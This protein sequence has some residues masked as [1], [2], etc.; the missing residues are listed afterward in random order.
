MEMNSLLVFSKSPDERVDLAIRKAMVLYCNRLKT[1]Y[2]PVGLEATFQLYYARILETVLS[3]MVFLN[4]SF[5]VILEDNNP[6]NNQKDYIDIVVVHSDE[7]SS[8]SKYFIEL[9]FKKLSDSAPN[10]GV[11]QSYID[12]YSLDCQRQRGNCKKGYYI[13]LTNLETY[14]NKPSTGTRVELPM[15]EG[16]IIEANKNYNVSGKTAKKA[17]S[18]YPEGFWFTSNHV[19]EYTSF[20][21]ENEKYWYYIESI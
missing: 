21:V 5:Q 18:K 1:G 10:S 11:I 12:M 6:I 4:E 2:Y 15:H 14:I 13:F 9:K 16:A 19:I 8:V 17:A 3:T 20:S 7:N